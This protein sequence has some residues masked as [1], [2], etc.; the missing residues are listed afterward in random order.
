MGGQVGL[1][2][3]RMM[4]FGIV[5]N[6]VNGLLGKGGPQGLQKG[7]ECL[8]GGMVGLG[9]HDLARRGRDGPK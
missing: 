2:D 6:Q 8:G 7:L 1:Q 3:L 5:Q 9:N 4:D